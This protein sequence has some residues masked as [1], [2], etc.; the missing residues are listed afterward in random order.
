[1]L[2]GP[3]LRGVPMICIDPGVHVYGWALFSAKRLHACGIGKTDEAWRP[4][5]TGPDNWI[6]EYPEQRGKHSPIKVATLIDLA[7]AAGR[8][9]GNRPCK[10]FRPSQWKGSIDK[11]SHHNAMLEVLQADEIERWEAAMSTCTKDTLLDLNDAIC[12]GLWAHGRL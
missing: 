8:I 10:F 2:H 1:M 4:K 3:P 5:D 11:T 6:C 12:L 7:L 9:V